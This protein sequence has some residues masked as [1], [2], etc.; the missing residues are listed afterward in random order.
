MGNGAST[1]SAKADLLTLFE[2]LDEDHKGFLTLKEIIH[3]APSLLLPHSLPTLYYSDLEKDGKVSMQEFGHLVKSCE[4][5]KECALR[6]LSRDKEFRDLIYR[7]SAAGVKDCS[8]YSRCNFRKVSNSCKVRSV[9]NKH[10][11]RSCSS[12]SSETGPC[13]DDVNRRSSKPCPVASRQGLHTSC[14]TSEHDSGFSSDDEAETTRA[15]DS[16]TVPVIMKEIG[17]PVLA[18]RTVAMYF[19]QREFEKFHDSCS[20]EF[21]DGREVQVLGDQSTTA[22]NAAVVE[23]INNR[24]LREMAA[25]LDNDGAREQFMN[26]LWKLTNVQSASCIKV[27]DLDLLLQALAEDNIDVEDLVFNSDRSVPLAQRIMMEFDTSHSEELTRDE[28]MV[29]ADLITREY[30]FWE[31]LHLD[32]VGDYELG[33]A[34]GKGSSAIVRCAAHVETR[35]KF[36]AKIIKRGNCSD[37]S[38]LDREISSLQL[39]ANHPG[40]VT[41]HEVL[42]SDDNVVLILELCGGGSLLDITRLYPQERMPERVAREFVQQLFDALAYC[43][44]HGVCHRDVRLENILLDN[45]G[46]LKL[47]DFGHSGIFAPDWDVFQTSL[48]GSVYNLSPEQIFGQCYSGEK[49]DVW[50]AGIVL[51]TLLVGHPPFYE[52]DTQALLGSITNGAYE[53][54][55]FVSESAQDLIETMIRVRKE[56]RPSMRELLKHRWFSCG[57]KSQVV[58]NVVNI[59]VD[60][61]FKKR[62]DLAEMIFA[63]TLHEFKVHFHLR[64]PDDEAGETVFGE[65]WRLFCSSPNINI[66]FCISLFSRSPSSGEK[67]DYGSRIGRPE[68]KP[69]RSMLACSPI[70]IEQKGVFVDEAGYD[71]D[72]EEDAEEEDFGKYRVGPKDDASYS[73]EKQLQEYPLKRHP[74]SRRGPGS[75]MSSQLP[76]MRTISKKSSCNDVKLDSAQPFVEV[77]LHEGES[78]LFLK[79]CRNLK[80]ICDTKLA[81]AAETHRNKY[82]DRRCGT[83][84]RDASALF[85]CGPQ[86]SCLVGGD[87]SAPLTPLRCPPSGA[88]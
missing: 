75:N 84:R 85:L 64:D 74:S 55:S 7:A 77:R 22:V 30:E 23:K 29:L 9:Y 15:S 28:F 37:M 56:D 61:F 54:P 72:D 88:K 10:A 31:N 60:P 25:L 49:L 57:P 79:I 58:M 38:R 63:G 48:V 44:E 87:S 33:R 11:R 81:S 36:A 62:P 34:L 14:A 39:V 24:Y 47:T 17:S 6:N 20:P 82:E 26:W 21:L 1:S 2:Y 50:S 83:I 65:E 19:S 46:K 76:I 68:L 32:C 43:H 69:G 59:P 12:S 3:A 67:R 51:Y 66:K 13:G 42:E 4:T 18:N 80:K 16:E 73:I 41:I 86:S 27:E 5:E 8:V 40:V 78:G 35:E 45:N 52:E 71:E 70:R 53:I